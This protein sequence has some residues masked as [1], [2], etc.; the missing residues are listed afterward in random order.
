[1]RHPTK[2]FE[3]QF[4]KT[5]RSFSNNA[6][7]H[8]EFLEAERKGLGSTLMLVFMMSDD[9]IQKA[10]SHRQPEDLFSRYQFAIKRTYLS[11]GAAIMA[12][13]V[14]RKAPQFEGRP[15]WK[16]FLDRRLDD[17]E[18]HGLDEWKPKPSEIWNG[19]DEMIAENYRFTLSYNK[20]TSLAS[21]T[22]IDDSPERSTGGYALSNADTDGALALKMAVYKHYVLLTKDWSPLLA[23][24]PKVRRG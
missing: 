12:K 20:T 15:E 13:R 6:P 5:S 16:G 3:E 4:P 24:P 17:D 2:D 18:L 22:V 7:T 1:M 9:L 14:T 21:C 23:I 10:A 11:E 8:E 19:V